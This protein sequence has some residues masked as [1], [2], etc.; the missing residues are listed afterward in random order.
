MATIKG[1]P[2][3]PSQDPIWFRYPDFGDYQR[4]LKDA[5]DAIT[6]QFFPDIPREIVGDNFKLHAAWMLAKYLRD[7]PSDM[8]KIKGYVQELVKDH[9]ATGNFGLRVANAREELETKVPRSTDPMATQLWALVAEDELLYNRL[10]EWLT[11]IH[12]LL[13]GDTPVA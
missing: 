11:T 7:Y 2:V 12:S 13:S 9:A 4:I 5:Q 6:C 8:E 10:Y 3:D 1:T